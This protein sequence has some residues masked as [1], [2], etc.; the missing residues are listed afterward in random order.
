MVVPFLLWPNLDYTVKASIT[1][2]F[3][4]DA[5]F[6]VRGYEDLADVEV[7]IR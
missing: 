2:G 7:M 3:E 4:D 5:G 1:D 6:I